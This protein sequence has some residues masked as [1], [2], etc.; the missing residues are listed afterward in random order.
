MILSLTC[1]RWGS[2]GLTGR[3]VFHEICR[4]QD[5]NVTE[6]SKYKQILVAGNNAVAVACDRC[7]QNSIV[8]AVSANRGDELDRFNHIHP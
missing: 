3:L 6:A 7:C 5:V 4:L 8:V 2:R 1:N